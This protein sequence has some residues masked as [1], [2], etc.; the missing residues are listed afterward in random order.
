[1]N[2]KPIHF[3]VSITLLF[4]LIL[5]A[6]STQTVVQNPAGTFRP[7]KVSA[8]DCNYGG[9]IKSVESIDAYT[10]KFSLCS[11]DSAFVSKIASPIFAVQDQDYLNQNKGDSTAMSAAPNGTAAYRL[12]QWTPASEIILES[13]T[14]YWGAPPIP[15]TLNFQWKADPAKRYSFTT[16]VSVDGVDQPPMSVIP[17]ISANSSIKVV[18][19][20]SN[21]LYFIGF[22]NASAPFDKIEVR[23][24]VAIALDRNKIFKSSFPQG[25][26]F[27]QQM[28]PSTMQSGRSAALKWYDTKPRDA[29]ELLRSVNYDPKQEITLAFS[30]GQVGYLASMATISAEIKLQLA[31][32]DVN[33]TLKP[34][35]PAEFLT[36][37]QQ[38]NEMMY[39]SWFQA[40]Y[41]DG[42][43]F[44]ERAFVRE[45]N[46]FGNP[47]PEI[48][49]AVSRV[50][51]VSN[52]ASRQ[53]VFDELNQL[54]KD[55]VP[56]IPLGHSANI[57]VFRASVKN[58]AAN[59]YYE[60]YEDMAGINESI[61]FV[62]INEP[63][64][65]WP[66]DE[67][68]YSTF[69]MTRLLYDTLTAPGFGDEKV[70]PLL[71]ESWSP[72]SDLTEWTFSLRYNVRFTNNAQFDANDVVSS[73]SAIWDAADPNH[74][75]RT[76]EFALYQR[77]FGNLLN[78]K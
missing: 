59:S 3:L 7:S 15:S 47:Y 16:M 48:Q 35:E 70:K 57:S 40:D 78:A 1:M 45:Q 17:D 43:A 26:E 13:S 49:Q 66:A 64:S 74:K 63:L 37:L 20:P 32:I 25:S 29:Q 11:P 38:G 23:K 73:F 71:A 24:A 31:A 28:V 8:Q 67:D 19:H 56:L 69:R 46:R 39:L 34:M 68:D 30:N 53:A 4:A 12:K 65:L 77:L 42:A 60:N 50:L 52:A 21:N 58:V 2:R 27:A 33:V 14:S 51:A 75:G 55:Q 41:D 10:V 76:G 72:N 54:V 5:S 62:G 44:F 9:E 6:C 61:Q 18:S 22:N 36:S